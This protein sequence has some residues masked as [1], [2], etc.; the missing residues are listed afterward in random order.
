L[1]NLI[2]KIFNPE[3]QGFFYCTLAKKLK[4]ILFQVK[5]R[6]GYQIKNLGYQFDKVSYH[7][8][9]GGYQFDKE[10]GFQIDNLVYPQKS[11]LSI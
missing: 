11:R 6:G 4:K 5:V 8:E 7:F 3:Y 2:S 10:R 1:K 9:M